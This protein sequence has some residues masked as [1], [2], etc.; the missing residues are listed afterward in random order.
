M[1]SHT[2]YWMV[3]IVEFGLVHVMRDMQELRMQGINGHEMPHHDKSLKE[4]ARRLAR[5]RTSL[6]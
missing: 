1:S 4:L 3:A 6:M 2:P 5:T